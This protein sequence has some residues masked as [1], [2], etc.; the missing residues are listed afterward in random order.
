MT[1]SELRASASTESA[2]TESASIGSALAWTDW[3]SGWTHRR[4]ELAWTL[5]RCQQWEWGCS[6]PV[7]ELASTRLVL[8]YLRLRPSESACPRLRPAPV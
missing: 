7:L 8:A 1:E 2:S 4:L 3:A 6:D 5:L